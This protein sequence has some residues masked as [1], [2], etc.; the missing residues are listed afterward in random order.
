MDVPIL[1]LVFNRPYHTRQTLEAIRKIRPSKM[2]IGADGP[3]PGN[4]TDDSRCAEVRKIV[5][6][7][8]CDCVVKTL[9]NEKNLGTK[10]AVSNAINW[11]FSQVEEGIII[12]DDCIPDPT[13][14]NY[15]GEMLA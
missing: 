10:T 13:F 2:F 1:F 5:S 7:I 9:F 12:E 6:G 15:A 14:Y 8:D 11:F 4:A 3:R